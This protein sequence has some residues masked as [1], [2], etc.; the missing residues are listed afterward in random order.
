MS[1]LVVKEE[2][3]DNFAIV[4]STYNIATTSE[5]L[6][7]EEQNIEPGEINHSDTKNP[8][9]DT[10][11]DKFN[12]KGAIEIQE[13]HELMDTQRLAT[14]QDPMDFTSITHAVD[15]KYQCSHCDKAFSY[16]RHL[17][18]H[19]GEKPYQCNQCDK[20]FSRHSIIIQ[21]LKIHFGDKPYQ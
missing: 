18:M 4:I 3:A 17:I 16:K 13:E 20:A 19:T 9:P 5:E 10:K 11:Y 1:E 15:R 2:R 7:K 12:V 6:I 8:D 14:D 21:H